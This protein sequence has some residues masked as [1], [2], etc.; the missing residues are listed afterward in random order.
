MVE[1]RLAFNFEILSVKNFIK[2]AAR[3]FEH[4]T[5]GSTEGVERWRMPFKA[6]HSF[7]GLEAELVIR[8][9]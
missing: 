3:D 6:D 5:V 7:R 1:V 2:P 8:F 4:E 9:L